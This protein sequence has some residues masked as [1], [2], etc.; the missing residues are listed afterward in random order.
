MSPVQRI[1]HQHYLITL[2][3]LIYTGP[4]LQQTAVILLTQVRAGAQTKHCSWLL[5][6]GQEDSSAQH[7][8][9]CHASSAGDPQ[10][11]NLTAMEQR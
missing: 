6:Q 4:N 7:P 10:Q 8:L 11:C 1:S 3:G 9:S 5:S 2:S